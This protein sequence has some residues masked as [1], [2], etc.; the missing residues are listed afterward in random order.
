M[1]GIDLAERLRDLA[2]DLHIIVTSALPVL[3]PVDQIPA[4]FIA[5]PYDLSAVCDMATTLLAA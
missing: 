2:P 3:R 4:T 1:N 5:K